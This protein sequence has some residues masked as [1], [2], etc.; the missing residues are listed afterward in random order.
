MSIFIHHTQQKK[1]ATATVFEDPISL[2]L[3]HRIQQVAPSDANALIIGETGTGKELVA[4]QIHALSQRAQG[5]FIAV[6]CGALTES[7][8]E[9][10]LFGHEKGAFTGAIQQRIGWF[11]AAHN[12]TLFL[13]EIGDLSLPM[14]VKLLRILQEREIIRVGS[15]KPIPINVRIIAATNVNLEQAVLEGKFREDLFY[16]LYVALLNIPKLADRRGDILPLAKF[17]VEKYQTNQHQTP[18]KISQLAHKKLIQHRW[19]GNI[20]E[21]ENTI[22]HAVLVSQHSII[23]PDDIS[24]SN[25][26]KMY[27]KTSSQY[28]EDLEVSP[29]EI[30]NI[31]DAKS[32]LSSTFQN[33]FQS[34]PVLR[35]LNINELIEESF[36]RSAYE[37]C[38]YNQVNT[39]KLLGVTRNVIRTRLIKYG[40]L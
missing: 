22:Q 27:L 17:F 20:R 18:I 13:D 23:E 1:R 6:N 40:L 8:A 14:Q 5:P 4:R 9:S 38:E 26:Q 19:P 36:I 7:L 11:E 37:F 15:L 32:L 21:L 2:A 16:R 3:L 33:L 25:L 12:G 24:F 29:N 10:E 31:Q 35:D 34:S 39:A 30:K 28:Y